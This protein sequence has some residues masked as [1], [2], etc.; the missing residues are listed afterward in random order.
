MKAKYLAILA[1]IGLSL[2]IIACSSDDSTTPATGGTPNDDTV[3]GSLSFNDFGGDARAVL[4]PTYTDTGL[5]VDEDIWHET[6]HPLLGKVFSEN[7]PMSIHRNIEDHDDVMEQIESM[8]ETIATAES[9]TGEIPTEPV[10]FTHEEHGSGTMTIQ[11][12]EAPAPIAVPAVCQTVFGRTSVTVDYALHIEVEFDG[13]G[14]YSTPYFGL[15][16]SEDA[17]VLYYWAVGMSEQGEPE[18]SQLFLA[19]KD[20]TT[21]VFEIAGSYFKADG[22]GEEER[23]NWVYHLTG[24]SDYDFEYN[25]GWY[26]ESPAFELFGC[27][28]GSGNKDVEFGLRFHQ[29][30]DTSGWDTY[31]GDFVSEEIFGPVGDDPYAFILDPNRA[32]TIDDYIDE[33][34]MYQRSDSPL[35]EIPNP[36]L[37]IF[38]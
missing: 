28:Q 12:V 38:E 33:S 36:F 18:G 24:T 16:A 37:T 32:G 9:E 23:C 22:P 4:P 25:M 29:Y 35:D 2:T 8:L 27:V 5:K 11:F 20:M 7:E 17:Q 1:M 26:S 30:T 15:S 3:V 31:E 34:V 13:G 21:E 10:P 19:T 14:T 6:S